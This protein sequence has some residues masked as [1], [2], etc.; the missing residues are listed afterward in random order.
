MQ[1][2]RLRR[3]GETPA[4]QFLL[5]MAWVHHLL[6]TVR[7]DDDP[8]PITGSALTMA[9][10]VQPLGCQPRPAVRL[11]AAALFVWAAAA[12]AAFAHDDVGDQIAAVTSLLRREPEH[13]ELYLKRGELWR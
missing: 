4:P 5:P 13:A 6:Y 1:P 12:P 9:A 7:L 11:I 3:A 10:P 2:S 8:D